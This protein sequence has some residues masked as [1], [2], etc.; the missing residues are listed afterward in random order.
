MEIQDRNKDGLI[1]RADFK[2]AVQGFM[3]IGTTEEQ[4]RKLTYTFGEAY[5]LV[6][7]VDDSVALTYDEFANR[8][9]KQVENFLKKGIG[10]NL[11]QSMFEAI[12]ADSDGRISFKEWVHYYKALDINIA[13]ARASFDAMDT[14]RDG[15]VSS[16]EF[17]AYCMEFFFS[18]KD[19]LRSSILYGPLNFK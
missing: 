14:N 6:G 1:E 19:T 8:F 16:K 3:D 7:I 11:F 12:D 15:V 9:A 13:Y 17:N 2:K 10:G 18:T 4:L 5:D